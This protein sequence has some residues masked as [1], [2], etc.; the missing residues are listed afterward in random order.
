[1]KFLVSHEE[2]EERLGE[3]QTPSCGY[4]EGTVTVVYATE[5][6]SMATGLVTGFVKKRVSRKKL[7]A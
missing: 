2:E 3:E 5:M 4:M 6:K 7:V 1:M